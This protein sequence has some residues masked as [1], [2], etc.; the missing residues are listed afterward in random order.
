[1]FTC[2]P[3][4]KAWLCKM[5][6][7]HNIPIF[8]AKSVA[9]LDKLVPNFKRF[10]T[11]EMYHY[12]EK[13]PYSGEF[14]TSSDTIKN[15]HRLHISLDKTKIKKLQTKVNNAKTS[16]KEILERIDERIKLKRNLEHDLETKM[17]EVKL[18]FSYLKLLFV[19]Y[20]SNIKLS[21]P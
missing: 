21:G 12:V 14:C 20:S 19:Q 4:I 13:S 15:Q 2:P 1:M 10:F 6:E 17:K 16:H 3:A 18:I 5:Y 11:G 8:G 7:I 9:K